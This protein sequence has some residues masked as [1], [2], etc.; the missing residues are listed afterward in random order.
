[1]SEE[2]K[3]LYFVLRCPECNLALFKARFIQDLPIK[4]NYHCYGCDRD[5][6]F[7]PDDV[8]FNFRVK[9]HENIVK[10]YWTKYKFGLN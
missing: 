5:I 4:Q 8:E 7:S 3:K 1:M 9:D 6:I 2:K 10:I